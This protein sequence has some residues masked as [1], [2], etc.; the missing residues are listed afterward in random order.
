M[1]TRP[2]KYQRRFPLQ[3]EKAASDPLDH[4]PLDHDLSDLDLSDHDLSKHDRSDHD[5]S[6]HEEAQ[7]VPAMLFTKTSYAK[8]CIPAE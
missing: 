5:P 8:D 3:P 6:E 7:S 1:Q 2:P 4:D